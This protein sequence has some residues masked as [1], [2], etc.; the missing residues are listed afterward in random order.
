[1][2]IKTLQMK[3]AYYNNFKF[4]IT[5]ALYYT[6]YNNFIRTFLMY[7]V[8]LYNCTKHDR[9][10]NFHESSLLTGTRVN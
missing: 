4:N 5:F 3:M 2:L 6:L 8:I 10:I 7:N 9:N 1:M